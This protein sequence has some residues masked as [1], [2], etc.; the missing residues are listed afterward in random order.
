MKKKENK[1][2]KEQKKIIKVTT[3][4]FTIIQLLVMAFVIYSIYL[5]NGIETEIRYFIMI[6]TLI[7]NIVFIIILKRILRKNKLIRYIIFIIISAI[8]IGVQGFLGFFI[9]KTYSSLDGLNKNKI[10]Y[11]SALVVLDEKDYKIDNL[12]NLNIGIINDTTS[13]DGYVLGVKIIEEKKL[14]DKNTIIEYED[15]STLMADLYDETLDAI[16]ISSN[17]PSMFKSI[18]EYEKI[19]TETKIIYEKSKEY[20]KSEIADYTG[21]EMVNFNT[22]DKVDKPFTV[23]VMGIDSAAKTLNKNATGNGDALMLVTFNPKTLNATILSIPRDTYVPIACFANQKEN[24]ITHAA[25]NGESCMIKTIQ[26]FT[27][28]KIDYYVKINFKGVTKLVDAL[29]GIEVD[30]PISFCESNSNRSTK[31]ENLIC[32]KEGK[33]T[34]NGEQALALARHR[35][36]LLT[37][38]LQR[39]VNQQLV[40]Q[41]ILNKAKTIR[42]TS[43]ALEILD[44]VSKNMDTNFTTK[45]MLSFYDILKSLILTSSENSNLINIQQLYLSGSGQNIYDEGIGLVL[46]NYIPNKSSLNQI[47]SVMEQNLGL[48]KVKMI[49]KMDFDIE[50][51]FEMET[52]GTDNLSAT[53]TY[54]L[55]PDFE[56]KSESYAINWLNKNNISYKIIDKEITDNSYSDGVVIKQSLPESKR[57]DLISGS[58]TLTI[59]RKVDIPVVEEPTIEDPNDGEITDTPAETPENQENTTPEEIPEN[60]ENTTPENNETE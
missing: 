3:N 53:S 46:Y 18:D 32:V 38:D 39:G 56:G 33:Q 22:S 43:Q 23:L 2:K 58:I 24:K 34:L 7:V 25:W 30:V 5:I 35:K 6:L 26:N 28:I 59:A 41:G 36:T 19:E 42:S 10:T 47:V 60:Q 51:K 15:F 57:I 55:L 50:D 1:D 40:V 49:K 45:Q 4:I 20:T 52:I 44:T 11:T 14:N 8:L 27:G 54:S 17:Y 37:G 9:F 21:E 16:I 48:E 13:I 29:G 12:K 31:E